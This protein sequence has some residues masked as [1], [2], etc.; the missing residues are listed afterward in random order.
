MKRF[1]LMHGFAAL[2]ALGLP[3]CGAEIP[4]GR[5]ACTPATVEA[6]CPAD[7]FCHTDGLCY[8]TD[9]EDAGVD[10]GRDM[11]GGDLG[12]GDLGGEDLGGGDAGPA[13][14][15]SGD[16]GSCTVD[17]PADLQAVD[18]NCDG[19]DGVLGAPGYVYVRADGQS[20]GN[21]DSV[22]TAVDLGRALVVANARTATDIDVTL[23]LA[24]GSYTTAAPLQI[25][26]GDGHLRW[27]GGYTSTFD[28]RGGGR[29]TVS[30]SVDRALLIGATE[31]SIDSVDFA[32]DSQTLA[33][34][35]TRTVTVVG[36]PATTFRNLTIRAGRGADGSPGAVGMSNM[37]MG[38][39]GTDGGDASSRTSRGSGGGSGASEGGNGSAPNGSA[40][41]P[42]GPST[43]V[44]VACGRGGDA[45][46]RPVINNCMCDTTNSSSSATG[47]PGE[48]GCPG[49]TGSA[50]AGG[51][52]GA[53]TLAADGSW[54][55]PMIAQPGGSGTIG[56][57]GGGGG[58]GG[59]TECSNINESGIN[60]DSSGGGGGEGGLP[61]GPGGGGQPG[62]TGGASLALVVVNS[63][64]TLRSV[65]LNPLGGGAG[66]QGGTGGA[67]ATGGMG[68]GGGSG[69]TYTPSVGGC[70]SAGTAD[71]VRG[72]AGGDGGQGG[73]GGT[74]GCGGG[75]GGGA[76]VGIFSTSSIVSIDGTVVFD[77]GAAG[78]AG[79]QCS[80]GGN[81]GALGTRQ[82]QVSL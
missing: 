53:G 10:L 27:V 67:G 64:V 44:G 38:G 79:P 32:T 2:V 12:S 75:G 60:I 5:F 6:D 29:S 45:G 42:G 43:V 28:A 31:V 50:G 9:T 11:G 39:M 51:V 7:W 19:V 62:G 68:G 69:F 14:Q 54:V 81:A 57:Q 48:P 22:A 34:R 3:A 56:N 49:G 63:T 66:G 30:S 70:G 40:P 20:T 59:D 25:A 74:G 36:S 61:G 72:G 58:G 71:R 16:G 4:E 26:A 78:A 24:E 37:T 82:N 80:T 18:S 77:L 33:G 76:T 23:L 8:S 15:G 1:N 35:S 65:T 52:A 46:G 47:D 41:E 17:D 55:P 21:G 13:D 73:R